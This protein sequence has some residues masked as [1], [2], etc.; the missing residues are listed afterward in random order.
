MV[1]KVTPLK[2]FPL[3]D[4]LQR[5]PVQPGFE[6]PQLSV[7]SER[8]DPEKHLQRFVAVVVLHGW[9]EITRCRAFPLSLVGQAQQ[10][11]TEIPAGHI[12]SFEQLKKEFLNAFSI[13]LPK[14]KSAIY[15]MSLQQKPNESLKQYI[16]RFRAGTQ[17]VRDLP[18]G[19]AA[20]A[21]L[22]GTTYTPLRRSLAFSE[23]NSL[24]E[25][26]DRAEQF[27]IQ[28]EIL[29]A[30]ESNRRGRET[31]HEV[32]RTQQVL[33]PHTISRG[34]RES[35]EHRAPREVLPNF[36]PRGTD[37]VR[38]AKSSLSS[39]ALLGPVEGRNCP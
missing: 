24:T 17:E 16:E 34:G 38:D 35:L 23:P 1:P 36:S 30:G 14:K 4:E 29:D 37:E 28:M 22:N 11:F 33:T 5:Q 12:R 39:E 27:I 25:L 18:A 9:N 7:Y 15:L 3:S 8:E 32:R 10:W 6:L 19:L 26:L 21:L 31:Q 13:Y 2:G 20:S